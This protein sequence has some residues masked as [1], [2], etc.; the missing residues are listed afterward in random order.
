MGV[1]GVRYGK[2]GLNGVED[3]VRSEGYNRNFHKSRPR[4]DRPKRTVVGDLGPEV[5][6]TSVLPGLA[7]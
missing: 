5:L 1:M 3:K 7:S 6:G 4:F 2:G